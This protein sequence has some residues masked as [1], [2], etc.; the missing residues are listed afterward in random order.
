MNYKRKNK[1]KNIVILVGV[2]AFIIGII[3]LTILPQLNEHTYTATITEK[4][5]KRYDDSD[6]YLIYTK[7]SDGTTRVF[8]NTDSMIRMKFNSS[9]IFAELETGKTYELKAYGFRNGFMSWYEN[10]VSV[11]EIK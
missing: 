8:E 4:Q 2:V 3:F 5:I 6:K 11:E 7:L 9:D 10:I 1:V